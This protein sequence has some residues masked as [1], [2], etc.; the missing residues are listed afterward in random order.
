MNDATAGEADATL[1]AN[2]AKASE[3]AAIEDAMLKDKLAATDWEATEAAL[4]QEV[5]QA[6][7]HDWLRSALSQPPTTAADAE[8]SCSS[9]PSTRPLT[10]VTQ[11]D[12]HGE[13]AERE[14]CAL[15]NISISVCVYSISYARVIAVMSQMTVDA[16]TA[17]NNEGSNGGSVATPLTQTQS[18]DDVDD[19]ILQQVLALS[20]QEYVDN[21]KDARA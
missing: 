7:Y 9:V 12:A 16:T 18:T 5:A 15:R 19:D 4:Q 6:S 10:T 21:M 17:I 13:L 1:L 3:T 8:P 14:L 11:S 20:Q 2:A